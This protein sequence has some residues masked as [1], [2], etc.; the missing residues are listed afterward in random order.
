MLALLRVES[1]SDREN[2]TEEKS[3]EGESIKGR[4]ILLLLDEYF[5]KD[6]PSVVRK[7][8][9]SLRKLQ[10]ALE[11]DSEGLILFQ[12]VIVSHCQVVAESA[13]WVVAIHKGSI[14]HEQEP[15]LLCLPSQFEWRQ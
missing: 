5:D 6:M 15:S 3:D 4:G 1:E 2:G 8:F 11:L 10:Q 12:L 7:V 9:T 13:D 14:F